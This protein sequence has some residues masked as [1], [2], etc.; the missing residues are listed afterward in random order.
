MKL[1]EYFSGSSDD[2]LPKTSQFGYGPAQSVK[3]YTTHINTE[4][5]SVKMMRIAVKNILI[6]IFIAFLFGI[7]L[8]YFY[9][10]QLLM[11]F[12]SG[13]IVEQC[14]SIDNLFVFILLFDYFR[15]P[16]KYQSRVLMYGIVG[17]VVMRGFFIIV[18]FELLEHFKFIILVFAFIL[19]YSSYKLIRE[20][21][22]GAAEGQESDDLENNFILQISKKLIDFSPDYDGDRFFTKVFSRGK[23]TTKATP[24]FLCLVCI[25]LSDLV[26]AVD[27]I[28]ACLGISHSALVVFSSNIFAVA[29]L[30][31]L[32]T[33]VSVAIKNLPFL[34][35]SVA[36]VLGFVGVKML[37]EFFRYELSTGWSLFIIAII[38]L[39]GVLISV[40]TKYSNTFATAKSN[41]YSN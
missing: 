35:V 29:C 33:L 27:S 8:Y 15:V 11:E 32:F 9:G 20:I 26:F 7:G 4:N 41:R 18:G 12:V 14:L 10:R 31:S 39:F 21:N 25:E 19:I 37:L 3:Q 24:L 40:F 28:P 30:R 5:D 34:K 1:F 13:Y 2:L 36:I 23:S 22:I 38:V 6:Q 17:A 16:Y